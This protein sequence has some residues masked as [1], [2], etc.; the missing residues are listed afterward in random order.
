MAQNGR[1][2]PASAVVSRPTKLWTLTPSRR[3]GRRP[4]SVLSSR[5]TARRDQLASSRV[6]GAEWLR[7]TVVKSVY[8]T[9]IVTVR[10]SSCLCGQPAD[11]VRRHLGDFLADRVEV[12]Q[13]FGVG[14]LRA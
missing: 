1:R 3:T 5:L 2:S 12:G 10:A 4:A 13:V 11:D 8:R 7:V 6:G 14:V 9:L